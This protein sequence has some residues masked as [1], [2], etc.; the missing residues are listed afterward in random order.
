MKAGKLPKVL[1]DDQVQ[2]IMAIPSRRYPTGIRNRALLAVLYMPCCLRISEAL[3]VK[4][5]DVD[6]KDGTLHVW[7]GKGAKDRTVYLD[8]LT[9]ELLRAWLDNRPNGAEA[10][11]STLKGR[12]V[13]TA[14]ARQMVARLGKKAEIAFRVHPHTFRHSGASE[15][16]KRGFSLADV[17]RI[18]G[19]SSI[20]TTAIYLHV[21]DPELQKKV[22]T[23]GNG[24]G[25]EHI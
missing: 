10:L 17:Q 25:N 2:A 19:H 9:K 3:A 21:H 24:A 7:R 16:L 4:P 1:T 12:P 6:L 15:L 13:S 14:Y 20:A 18:L 11:F 23:L 5:C 8:G 22:Q